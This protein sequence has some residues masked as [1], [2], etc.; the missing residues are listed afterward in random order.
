MS[1]QVDRVGTKP[2]I[3]DPEHTMREKLSH[4]EHFVFRIDA[5]DRDRLRD[6]FLVLPSSTLNKYA[7]LLIRSIKELP[8][9]RI[10]FVLMDTDF[11]TFFDKVAELK[12]NSVL[13]KMFRVERAEQIDHVLHA[14]CDGLQKLRFADARV[15]GSTL[16]A[17]AC[18]LSR[19]EIDLSNLPLLRDI[20]PA[21]LHKP[22][23][24]QSGTKLSWRERHID[25]DFDTVRYHA[26]S[27]YRRE[28]DIDALDYYRNYGDAIR[29]LR[30]ELGLTQE[31]IASK[32]GVSTRHL[33]R[34]ENGEQKPTVKL[35][36][37]L[38][39][40]HGL[41]F[42]EYL[43]RLIRIC[44]DLE[45][46]AARR[47]RMGRRANPQ[48]PVD[49]ALQ[50][51]DKETLDN[52]LDAAVPYHIVDDLDRDSALIHLLRWRA[53]A[54]SRNSITVNAE[55]LQ[56]SAAEAEAVN[57]AASW[58]N[59]KCAKTTNFTLGGTD[60]SVFRRIGQLFEAACR[61]SAIYSVMNA[62]WLGRDKVSGCD[63]KYELDFLNEKVKILS[64]ADYA[65]G[66]SQPPL[67]G[68]T[69]Q[70]L[71][72]VLE[73]L[74]IHR[75][76]A[77]D[78]IYKL[79]DETFEFVRANLIVP[80]E[81]PWVLESTWTVGSY[82]IGN[83]RRFW[84]AL[85]TF[86]FVNTLACAV[87]DKSLAVE[88]PTQLCYPVNTAV[89]TFSK[90]EWIERLLRWS[91]LDRGTVEQILNDLTVDLSRLP[92][93]PT[94]GGTKA[95]TTSLMYQ[96]FVPVG[97]V[98]ALDTHSV[99]ASMAERNLLQL[100]S[101]LR[102]DTFDALTSKK[103]KSWLKEL[104]QRWINGGL[105]A[106]N[107]SVA[108]GKGDIDVLLCDDENKFA[109]AIQAKFLMDVDRYKRDYI[110]YILKAQK[111]ARDGVAWIASNKSQA[112]KTMGQDSHAVIEYEIVP[113][114]L[115]KNQMALEYADEDIPILNERLLCWL[116]ENPHHVTLKQAWLVAKHLLYV[117]KMENDLYAEQ[118]GELSFGDTHF[119]FPNFNFLRDYDP[120]KD[121]DLSALAN[122]E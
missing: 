33:S 21:Q 4:S 14:W 100:I 109:I 64:L 27:K 24:D 31:S 90:E 38:A 75:S 2:V 94:T 79:D 22:T 25:I 9:L 67:C 114:V 95:K 28:R 32:T 115:T 35:V 113:L 49:Y 40:A 60:E 76:G 70:A 74:N 91:Q 55:R 10:I 89:P 23:I 97:D 43:Q 44:S 103:E 19:Y 34:V 66:I 102:K 84:E 78:L 116:L 30:E 13:S 73:Q 1:T 54:A 18:D 122:F 15:E 63:H 61:F 16:I 8:K 82:T 11:D 81:P 17:K 41:T 92:G 6:T 36:D 5:N 59:Y 42:G 111:Q 7:D 107:V 120:R 93:L 62:V 37:K 26:D 117:P 112:A 85:A 105:V 71:M 87:T 56:Q 46:D 96:P 72:N 47:R 83:Y 20:D 29:T 58:I 51:V 39:D 110:N 98:L 53:L 52:A 80:R 3:I 45:G 12:V 119:R 118:T 106:R 99:T 104:E 69:N 121:I 86:S 68:G 88:Y 48:H 57:F 108:Q 77:Y 65:L 50:S 101:I